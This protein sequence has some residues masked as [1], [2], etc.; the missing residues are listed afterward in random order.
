MVAHNVLVVP[1]DHAAPRIP[2]QAQAPVQLPPPLMG[3]QGGVACVVHGVH[4]GHGLEHA[5][6]GGKGKPDYKGRPPQENAVHHAVGDGCHGKH[7]G[8]APG[9]GPGVLCG[10]LGSV[11]GGPRHVN[12]ALALP[13]RSLCRL[14]AIRV[15]KVLSHA[16]AEVGVKIPAVGGVRGE[17]CGAHQVPNA[18][19]LHHLPGPLALIEPVV[20]SKQ[21]RALTAS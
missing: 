1:G 6:Q 7:N 9:G 12:G 10:S 19:L 8:Q 15:L 18:V 4:E 3:A 14:L 2:V 16:P 13:R 20:H 5:L 21:V 17:L 11:P